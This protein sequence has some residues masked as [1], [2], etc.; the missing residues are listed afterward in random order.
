MCESKKLL[1]REPLVPPVFIQ[2]NLGY[3]CQA[4][5]SLLHS[6]AMLQHCLQVTEPTYPGCLDHP[7]WL[8]VLCLSSCLSRT[9]MGMA[10]HQLL[11]TEF[12]G[13]PQLPLLPLPAP[14][15]LSSPILTQKLRSRKPYTWSSIA[16]SR[17]SAGPWQPCATSPQMSARSCWTRYQHQLCYAPSL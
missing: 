15:P 4:C 7:P 1:P 8:P 10:S 6:R 11:P 14:P 17:S 2:V 3:L 13:H 9:K 16:F 5:A 12:S